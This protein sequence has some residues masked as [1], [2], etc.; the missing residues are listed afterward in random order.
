MRIH[1]GIASNA[2]RSNEIAG[3]GDAATHCRDPNGIEGVC[4]SI[5]Q[6][7]IILKNF[8]R[9]VSE[10]DESYIHYIRQS[11]AICTTTLEPIICCP[12]KRRS[13]AGTFNSRNIEIK[14]MPGR[15]PTP[16]EGCGLGK[17]I[18][19]PRTINPAF[20]TKSGNLNGEKKDEMELWN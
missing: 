3:N 5:K 1:T 6:C 17:P 13:N 12:T 10:R 8:V 16:E 14:A 15:L 4:R 19:R 9:L 2:S 18:T 11:N 20:P 7:P